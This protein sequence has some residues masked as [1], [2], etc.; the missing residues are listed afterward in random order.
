MHRILTAALDTTNLPP[1]RTL[2]KSRQIWCPGLSVLKWV[3]GKW[4][5]GSGWIVG[6]PEPIVGREALKLRILRQNQETMNKR[7]ASPDAGRGKQKAAAPWATA[8]VIYAAFMSRWGE[9]LQGLIHA[10]LH[11][12][13]GIALCSRLVVN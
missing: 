12:L 13:A 7:P 3:W 4:K 8:T 5:T 11:T 1:E 6:K 10:E 2:A 9:L